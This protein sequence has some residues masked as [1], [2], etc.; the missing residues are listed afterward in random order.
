VAA[1]ED[2]IRLGFAV[3]SRISTLARTRDSAVAMSEVVPA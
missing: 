2:R 3:T 1:Q